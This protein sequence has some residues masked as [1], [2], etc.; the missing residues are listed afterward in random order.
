MSSASLMMTVT[1]VVYMFICVDLQPAVSVLLLICVF[2]GF[3]VA[4]MASRVMVRGKQ[5]GSLGHHDSVAS[6]GAD[7]ESLTSSSLF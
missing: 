6:A 4:T 2:T 7:F 1:Y 3:S 5:E